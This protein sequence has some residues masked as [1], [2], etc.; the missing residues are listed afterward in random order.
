MKKVWKPG[1]L[2]APVPPTMVSC[3]SMEKPNI[4]TVGWTGITCSDP[5]QTYVSIRKER[6]SHK[7]IS[8]TGTFVINLPTVAL[9]KECDFCGVKSGRDTD[10]FSKLGLTPVE[11]E[12]TGCPAIAQ[13]PVSIECKVDQ[14]IPLGSH[15]MF[16]ATI[17]SVSVDEKLVEESGRLALEKANLLAYAHGSYFSLGK[18]VG[19]FGF[20]V[21]KKKKR[22]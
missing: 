5:A 6:Y 15:D 20:S 21:R 3:G 8:E 4:I 14:V 16:M 11:S 1:T 9:A 22:R 19:T 13:C 7:L 2:L 12:N 17:L 10:K 18:S